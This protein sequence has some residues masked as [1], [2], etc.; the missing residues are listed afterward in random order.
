MSMGN[1]CAVQI[2][3]GD[4]PY[5]A[6]KTWTTVTADVRR[7]RATTS[8]RA[9]DFDAFG[10]GSISIEL[11]NRD[12]DYDPLYSGSP[13]VNDFKWGTPIRVLGHKGGFVFVTVWQGFARRFTPRYTSS[14]DSVTVV[15][16]FDGLGLLAEASLTEIASAYAGDRV[17]TRIGRILD[18]A[19]WPS[20]D[21][22]LDISGV[23]LQ[24]TTWG[25]PVLSALTAAAQADGG[26]VYYEPNQGVIRFEHRHAV[27]TVTRMA[28]S[29]ETFGTG[30]VDILNGTL[31][32][33]GVGDLLRNVVHI[34][35]E[36]GAQSS[37]GTLAA[38]EA[39][40][41]IDRT[42]AVEYDSQ[43]QTLADY[44]LDL[45]DTEIA[46]PNRWA[47]LTASAGQAAGGAEFAG[48][49]TRLR[50]RVTVAYD[51]PGTGTES[52]GVFIDSVAHDIDQSRWITSY[53]ATSVDQYDALSGS[54]SW[55]V[56]GDATQGKVGTGRVG[57]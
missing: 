46:S 22:D 18:D 41:A 50:D 56:I 23:T 44:L 54:G 55:L 1:H 40:K 33:E 25:E 2:A 34:T 28:S 38:T 53:G 26:F 57:Y 51:P 45:Y 39:E 52:V 9:S 29:Q 43:A 17:D 3:F 14:T 19:G 7:L 42:V 21:R 24:A 4:D 6:S 47:I 8:R 48:F 13:Y 37:A 12:R 15:E 30:G 5:T 35:R 10:A 31:T 36:G 32:V 49:D 20:G 16:G 27:Q 11:D